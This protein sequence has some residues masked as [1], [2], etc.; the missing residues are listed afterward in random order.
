MLNAF[1]IDIMYLEDFAVVGLGGGISA[2]RFL[3]SLYIFRNE[4]IAVS[5]YIYSSMEESQSC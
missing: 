1:V 5:E 4:I 2:T 3:P